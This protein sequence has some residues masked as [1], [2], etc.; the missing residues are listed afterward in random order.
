MRKRL[1]RRASKS[2]ATTLGP[3]LLRLLAATWRVRRLGADRTVDSD[4]ELV[5]GVWHESI[6]AGVALNRDR[7][8]T[9]LISSHHDGEVITRIV[10]SFGFRPARGSSSR[11]GSRALREMLRAAGESRGLVVTPDGPRG[12]AHQIA[13]GLLYLAGV[14]G[15]PVVA[16]GFAA[17][18][19]W[20]ARSWDRMII[21]KPFA[22]VVLC[23]GD[24]LGVPREALRDDVLLEQ[25]LQQLQ[26][27]FAAAHQSAADTLREWSGRA[28]VVGGPA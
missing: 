15:R 2:L 22:K 25:S 4:R 1:L 11:G 10:R 18:R 19:A 5:Y 9:V 24:D 14:T 17:T 28:D 3:W 12:P 27:R 16:T 26:Q 7:S 6:P 21:P 20:R 8:L 23:F 13:P